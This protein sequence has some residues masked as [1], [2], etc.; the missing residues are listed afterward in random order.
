M[1]YFL[2][3]AAHLSLTDLV[4]ILHCFSLKKGW[5][6]REVWGWGWGWGDVW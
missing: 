5:K 1:T 2:N 4:N 3:S 6:Y